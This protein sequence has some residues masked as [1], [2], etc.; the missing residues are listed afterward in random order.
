MYF[1][2]EE[3]RAQANKRQDLRLNPGSRELRAHDHYAAPFIGEKES[4]T[5]LILSGETRKHTLIKGHARAR[6]RAQKS[7]VKAG[8]GTSC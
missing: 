2:D 5:A 6:S 3:T 1:F 7:K 8:P 4:S